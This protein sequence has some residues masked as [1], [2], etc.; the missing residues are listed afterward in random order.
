MF[1]VMFSIVNLE[2]AGS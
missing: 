1:V 2:A